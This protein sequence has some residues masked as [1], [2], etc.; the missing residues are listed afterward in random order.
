MVSFCLFVFSK[1]FADRQTHQVQG[2]VYLT[3]VGQAL[4][5]GVPPLIC[6]GSQVLFCAECV[7]LPRIKA[8]L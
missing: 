2:H 6:G 3:V 5:S 1:A 7:F 4:S 8:F